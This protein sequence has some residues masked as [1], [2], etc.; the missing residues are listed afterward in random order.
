MFHAPMVDL[1]RKPKEIKA[2]KAIAMPMGSAEEYP[3]GCCISLD[4]ETLG[5]LKLDGD[6][7]APGEMI[8]FC[9]VAKVTSASMN[10]RMD[11]DGKPQKCCR[12]ELQIV[13]MGAPGTNEERASRWYG[14]EEPDEDE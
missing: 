8:H 13:Q 7:P 14:G 2:E 3:Y 11:D 9:C 1:K 12:V 5:A 10:E 4:D 6:L